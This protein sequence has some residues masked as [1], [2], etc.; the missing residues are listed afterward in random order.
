[1]KFLCNVVVWKNKETEMD[2][3][4]EVVRMVGTGSVT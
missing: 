4:E 2:A 3:R 1:M